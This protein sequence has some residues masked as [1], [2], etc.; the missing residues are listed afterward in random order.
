MK[1][2]GRY[3]GGAS[4]LVGAVM[5]V[6]GFAQQAAEEQGFAGI[7]EVVVTARKFEESLQDAPIA[8]SAFTAQGLEERN[9]DTVTEIGDF[10]PNVKFNS[11]VPISASNATVA[12][13]IRGIGQNDYQLS[14]DPGVGLYLDGVYISRNV[15]NVLDIVDVERIEVLRGPQGTLFGRNTIGG[16]VNVVTRKP[17]EE[18]GGDI[19]LTTGRWNRIQTK[20]NIDLPV[21][22]GLYASASGIFHKRDGYVKGVLDQ[23]PDLGDTDQQGGRIA[24]RYAPDDQDF[25]FNLAL[26]GSRTR[27]ESAPN[28]L[29]NM[30]DAPTTF[31]G[32]WNAFYAGPGET[33]SPDLALAPFQHAGT[34]DTILPEFDSFADP[35]FP[36]RRYESASDVDIWGIAGTFDWDINDAISFKSITSYRTVKGYWTRESDHT[37]AS[38]VQT[39]SFWDHEQFSQELQLQGFALDSKLK[40]VAGAYY[41]DESGDH[42]DMVQII[43][44]YFASGAIVGGESLAFFGQATY[45]ITPDLSFTAGI[46]WTEDEKTFTTDQRVVEAGFLTGA[47]LNPDGSGIANGDPLMGP[48]GDMAKISDKAWTPLFTLSYRWNESLMTYASYSEGFKGG[49]FTQRVFPPLGYIPS[50]GPETS[51]TYEV[52]FKGDFWSNKARLNGAMFWNEYDDLQVTVN[53]PILGFAPIIQNAAKARIRGA[54]L[55]LLL[56]PTPDLKI[57]AAIGYLDAEYKQVDITAA[58]AGTGGGV[59]AD[60]MLQNAP[61]WTLSAGVSYDFDLG[62]AGLVTPRVDWSYRSKVANDAVNTPLLIQGGYHIVNASVA[63]RTADELWKVTAGVKNLTNEKYLVSGYE[64]AG[65]GITEGVYARP[66][67]WFASVKRAF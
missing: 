58:A 59:T 32:I 52:G 53:D 23:S 12:L 64:D 3:L 60:D 55:E 67:E 24:L 27:E 6:C 9:L 14:A 22:D 7:E 56:F 38:V 36:G 39:K 13:F 4:L 15:G 47:P 61:E 40:W 41:S 45:D 65:A 66:R 19:E 26:D 18:F 10:A 43:D 31:F 37:P 30:N 42:L 50:F 29:I 1:G 5:P 49:G 8:I 63:Y 2:L 57:D 33:V 17:A 51:T 48:I 11:A 25:E 16:A 34:W 35:R 46:R 28:V 20:F 44:A 62:N 54:E 21:A